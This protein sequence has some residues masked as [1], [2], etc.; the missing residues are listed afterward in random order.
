M[1][2]SDWQ[3]EWAC[4][5]AEIL[6][7][8]YQA[9]WHD[10]Y[11]S[12]DRIAP[13]SPFQHPNV[14]RAWAESVYGLDR[15]TP[16]FLVA[17]SLR[18]ETV[19]LPLA[20]PITG[21]NQGYIKR[22][23][24]VGARYFDYHDPIV[25]APH[26]VTPDL[27]EFWQAFD[28]DISRKAGNWYDELDLTRLRM[29]WS[30]PTQNWILADKAPYLDLAPY[31]CLDEFLK[32]RSKSLRGDL[33]RQLRRA[34]ELGTVSY[35]THRDVSTTEVE[36]WITRLEEDRRRRF[37]GSALPPGYLTS[38]L[39]DASQPD[40]S[41]HFSALYIG[42]QAVSW[43]AGFS[44]HGVYYWYVPAFDANYS[45]IS[46]GKI[47][48]MLAIDAAISVR[49]HTFDFLRG[50]ETYKVGWTDEGVTRL[51]GRR[52]LSTKPAST[53]RRRLAWGLNYLGYAKG[54]LLGK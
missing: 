37:P 21:P 47:H 10:L 3:L 23:M 18:G 1:T 7:P 54:A 9:M 11:R 24:P 22:L 14:V 52:S 4:S 48:I 16:R 34:Q 39:H 41:A 15:L 35:K 38:L 46:P 29:S 33:R 28:E 19:F 43:H 40:G 20:S 32:S 27:T 53:L 2:R 31:A 17:R 6:H 36:A 49:Q 8:H 30:D 51:Y 26:S 42:E 44:D 50:M 25:C 45:A 5:W 13:K 12:A